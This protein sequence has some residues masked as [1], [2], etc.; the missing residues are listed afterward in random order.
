MSCTLKI[1]SFESRNATPG[2]GGCVKVRIASTATLSQ[3]LCFSNITADSRVDRQVQLRSLQNQ[4]R[5]CGCKA[6][7]LLQCGALHT[8]PCLVQHFSC[9]KILIFSKYVAS[10]NQLH[11]HPFSPMIVY[12]FNSLIATLGFSSKLNAHGQPKAAFQQ[13]RWEKER[14]RLFQNLATFVFDW[15]VNLKS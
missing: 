11:F 8:L 14:C 13:F 6:H 1:S 5:I 12:H 7:Y 2:M 10:A 15:I 3:P 9:H 4:A